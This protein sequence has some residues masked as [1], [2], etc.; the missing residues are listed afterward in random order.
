MRGGD[1]CR[2]RGRDATES[3]VASLRT[4]GSARDF[5]THRGGEVIHQAHARAALPPGEPRTHRPHGAAPMPLDEK[6]ALHPPAWSCPSQQ[7]SHATL[8]AR[9][10]GAGGGAGGGASL[11]LCRIKR[12]R[13]DVHAVE[14]HDDGSL[15]LTPPPGGVC[16][17]VGATGRLP[18]ASRLQR[19]RPRRTE[20][21]PSTAALYDPRFRAITRVASGV[22]EQ[23]ARPARLPPPN[24]PARRSWKVPGFSLFCF[25]PL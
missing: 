2:R 11:P 8:P 20:I 10:A 23:A 12:R 7:C 13:A 17:R 5:L 22:S 16:R 9:A 21:P 18:G 1:E 6:K 3:G 4:R 24:R 14:S 25:P 19:H 15:T